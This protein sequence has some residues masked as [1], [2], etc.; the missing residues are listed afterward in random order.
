MGY[1]PGTKFDGLGAQ[2]QRVIAINALGEYWSLSVM[3]QPIEEIAIHP[4]DGFQDDK[5]YRVFLSNVNYSIA[6]TKIQSRNSK[7]I[8]SN[9]LIFRDMLSVIF[10][11]LRSRKPIHFLI[12][13]PYFFVDAYPDMYKCSLN[14]LVSERISKFSSTTFSDAIVVHHRHGVG[15]MAIQPGQKSPREISEISLF[16]SL[17]RCISHHP[18]ARIVILTDAPESDIVFIPPSQQR[19]SW[20][21]LPKFDGVSLK[22][23]G[24]SL[25]FI[26]SQLAIP[27]EI[28]RGGNPLISLANMVTSD[29]LFLSRS[30]FGYVAAIL[31]NPT[32]VWIPADF[33]HAPLNNWFRFRTSESI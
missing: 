7:T 4:L 12:S 10:Q 26:R 25:D 27:I 6:A 1:S 32:E 30:S 13:H 21:N 14:T 23:S 8:Y 2:L 16:Q 28:I 15:N 24:G 3:H 5:A 22:V 17:E 31:G 9:D 19:N 33:W 11:L 18:M 20:T 29:V